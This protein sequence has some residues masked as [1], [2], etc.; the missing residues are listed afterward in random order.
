MVPI[1]E[2]HNL[3]VHYGGNAVVS[4]VSLSC[5]RGEFVS[6]VGRSGSGKT[7][8]LNAIAGLVPYSGQIGR[9]ARC[10]YVFQQHALFPWM[11]VAGNIAFGLSAMSSSAR[12]QRVREMLMQIE[13]EHF[14]HRY[15]GQLSG[16]Q[17]HRVA[18]ARALAPEPD[19]VLMD[20]PYAALD[21]ITRERMQNWLLSFWRN[22]NTTIV[23]VT[24][25]LDEAIFLAD[26]VLVL[27]RTGVVAEVPVPFP[28]PRSDELRYTTAFLALRHSL[29]RQLLE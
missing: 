20:E 6:I 7:T 5:G 18:L 15:P 12:S 16:G 9:P 13:M 21:H 10:G 1:I 26:R 14:G 27:R 25:Q 2:V 17:S 22:T 24:H 23:F 3:T 29:L 11:T 19:I 8:V 4:G 28:R